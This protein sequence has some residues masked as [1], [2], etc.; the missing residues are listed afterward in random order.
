M[1]G[2]IDF[3][4][5]HNGKSLAYVLLHDPDWFFWAMEKHAFDRHPGLM[6]LAHELNYKARNIKI[7]KPNPQDWHLRYV[8][9]ANGKF[10]RF[11]IIQATSQDIEGYFGTFR[12]DRL[13]L[14]FPR[15]VK[16]YDKLGGHLLLRSFRHYFFGNKEARLTRERCEVFFADPDNFVRSPPVVP[17][18]L[19]TVDLAK[20]NTN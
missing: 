4:K 17:E 6:E 14:S 15:Q 20:L 3:G 13:D 18:E 2:I 1:G 11:E 16:Q 12:S 9:D 7:P 19:F 8:M 5:R 10:E